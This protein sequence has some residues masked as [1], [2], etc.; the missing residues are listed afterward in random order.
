MAYL[1]NIEFAGADRCKCTARIH[2]LL[3]TVGEN[4]SGIDGVR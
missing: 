4:R 3:V 1:N 2:W